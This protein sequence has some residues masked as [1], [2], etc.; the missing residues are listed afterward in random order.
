MDM[1]DVGKEAAGACRFLSEKKEYCMHSLPLVP[2]YMDL[3]CRAAPEKCPV[4]LNG[5]SAGRRG[6]GWTVAVAA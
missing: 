5:P 1:D 3:V 4:Y 2:L 6:R